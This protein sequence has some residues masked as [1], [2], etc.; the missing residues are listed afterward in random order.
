MKIYYKAILILCVFLFLSVFQVFSQKGGKLSTVVIDP[1]HGGI[2][3][4]TH[5]KKSKEKDIV[6]AV[7]LKLG[8][9]IKKN[10]PDVKVI[11]TRK[12]DTFVPL[13]TRAKIGNDA[14]ADLFISIHANFLGRPSFSG[15]ETYTLGLHRTKDN[16][17]VAKKENSVIIL[18]DDYTTTYENFDPNSVESY[19]IFE[20]YQN[21]YLNQSVKMAQ[22]IE[23]EFKTKAKRI[24][25]GVKQA[26]FLVLR[27]TAMPSVLIELGYLSNAKEEAFLLSAKGQNI[28]AASIYRAFKQ[29]KSD[30]DAANK[31]ETP[32]DEK[33]KKNNIVY[34]IQVATMR[35]KIS[36]SHLLY[37]KYNDVYEYKVGKLYK[38]AVEKASTYDEIIEKKK[39]VKRK[40]KDCFIIAYNNGNKISVKEAHKLE[41]K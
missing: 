39:R 16:L 14:N 22:L 6:L 36:K 41:K 1:G 15:T 30:Y 21:I 26:G 25:R 19:I 17:D 5:G 7:S 13:K 27:E 29:Y 2:D 23:K 28:L 8:E 10:L 18:E 35:K 12:T 20:L 32:V 37:R 34:R 31:I 24:S 11:F 38:Y 3:P 33:V 4:G 40:Y 9:Y